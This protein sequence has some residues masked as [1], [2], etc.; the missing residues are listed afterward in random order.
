MVRGLEVSSSFL[1]GGASPQA[2]GDKLNPDSG[3]PTLSTSHAEGRQSRDA[4][5]NQFWSRVSKQQVGQVAANSPLSPAGPYKGK[6]ALRDEVVVIKET[7]K[8]R[9]GE[10]V[11]VKR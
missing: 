10:S 5:G 6:G 4:D 9:M 8:N 11:Q 7:K 3:F 1:V 2:Q